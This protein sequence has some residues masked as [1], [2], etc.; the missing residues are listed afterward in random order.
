V[1]YEV[2]PELV[3]LPHAY[4]ERCIVSKA[5]LAVKGKQQM[6]TNCVVENPCDSLSMILGSL[7]VVAALFGGCSYGKD[8]ET[9]KTYE[10]S[11]P[12]AQGTLTYGTPAVSIPFGF[13]PG[14]DV[15]ACMQAPS[16]CASVSFGVEGGPLP[17]QVKVSALENGK[18]VALPS[19]NVVVSAQLNDVFLGLYYDGGVY[20]ESLT[21]IAG[22]ITVTVSLNNFDSRFDMTF[23]SANGSEVLIDN[24]RAAVLNAIWSQQTSC[25]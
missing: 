14:S 16:T 20:Q 23:T 22:S 12:P 10:G 5:L 1:T 25:H 13:G 8:C 15:Y 11:F 17:I 3:S 21:L 24:G 19:P 2:L 9:N 18:T 4:P 7:M 6:E